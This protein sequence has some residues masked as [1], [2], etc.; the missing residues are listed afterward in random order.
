MTTSMTTPTRPNPM[1]PDPEVLTILRALWQQHGWLEVGDGGRRLTLRQERDGEYSI[2][3][4]LSEEL[5]AAIRAHRE[6]VREYARHRTLWVSAEVAIRRE[7]MRRQGERWQSERIATERDGIDYGKGLPFLRY[8]RP[9]YTVESDPTVCQSCGEV[10]TDD[11]DWHGVLGLHTR[12]SLCTEAAMR[13][14]AE[15][16]DEAEAQCC[17]G[18]PVYTYACDGTP[19][20]ERHSGQDAHTLTP[21]AAA[22]PLCGTPTLAAYLVVREA[23][24]GEDGLCHLCA[25]RQE[26]RGRG[27]APA[28]RPTGS[29]VAVPLTP[30]PVKGPPTTVVS[31]TP[32]G[33]SLGTVTNPQRRLLP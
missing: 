12:C 24:A 1:L 6:A 5:L 21:R 9:A 14:R 15:L 18:A 11:P 4:L 27:Q 7:A 23:G 13:V 10:L 25:G 28:S 3:E 17:C 22:C 16:G 33:G 29:T 26:L 8:T 31:L 19:L 30:R 20:C 32:R 2:T